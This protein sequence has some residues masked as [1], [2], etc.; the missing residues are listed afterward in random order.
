MIS[1]EYKE[2]VNAGTRA[3]NSLTGKIFNKLMEESLDILEATFDE[4]DD[5][6]AVKRYTFFIHLVEC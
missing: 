6:I 2:V 4:F 3:L 1:S 5:K